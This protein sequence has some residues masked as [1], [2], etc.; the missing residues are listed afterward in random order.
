MRN[1]SLFICLALRSA[2]ICHAHYLDISSH[3]YFLLYIV[4]FALYILSGLLPRC[5]L[6]FTLEFI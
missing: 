6:W 2:L 4:P 5:I 3:T 1:P